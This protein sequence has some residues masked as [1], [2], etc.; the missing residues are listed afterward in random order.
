MGLLDK[1]ENLS[2]K[3]IALILL[4]ALALSVLLMAVVEFA[5]ADKYTMRVNVTRDEGSIG[6]NPLNTSLDFGDVA[7][8]GKAERF[9][10]LVNKSKKASNILILDW[11]GIS[12]LVKYKDNRFAIEAGAKKKISFLLKVPPSAP[13]GKYSGR[14]Y[15]FRLPK[16]F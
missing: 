15:I 7:R 4:G 3:S 16:L 10:T 12:E 5:Y 13:L 9:I 2:I 6:I 1:L 14:I 8:G 11:G